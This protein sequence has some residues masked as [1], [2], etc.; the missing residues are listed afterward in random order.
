[1]YRPVQN[2]FGHNIYLNDYNDN[3]MINTLKSEIKNLKRQLEKEKESNIEYINKIETISS[4]RKELKEKLVNIKK[5][6]NTLNSEIKNLKRQLEK[7]KK[8]NT[9]YINKI[10]SISSE[11][12][13]LEKNLENIKNENN[14][15]RIDLLTK[16]EKINS[17][18]KDLDDKIQINKDLNNT[19]NI[20]TSKYKGAINQFEDMR[21]TLKNKENQ[22]KELKNDLNDLNGIKSKYEDLV[23]INN[24]SMPLEENLTKPAE[25]FYDVV[26]DITSI[27]AL[28]SKGWKIYYNKLRREVYQKIISDETIKLGVVGL[29]NVG[30][31]FILSK[32]SRAPLQSGYSL[33]TKGISIKYSEKEKGEEAGICVLD[34][35]GFETPLLKGDLEDNKKLNEERS[36]FDKNLQ[37]G[38]EDDLSRDKAQIERFIEQL[39]ISLSDLIIIVVGKISR[40]EQKLINQIKTLVKK[41]EK[42]KIKSI[43]VIHNLANY[44][45]KAEVEKYKDQYLVRSAT[46]NLEE[47]KAYG[48]SGYEDRYYFVERKNDENNIEV[49]H[50]LMAKEGQEAG[51]YYNSLTLELIRRNYISC[52]ERNKINIPEEIIKLFSETSPEILGEYRELEKSKEDEN[53]IKLA[54][55]KDSS[56][57]EVNYK[58]NV[59]SV[60]TD[61]DGNYNFF[62]EKYEPPYSLYFYKEKKK[63]TKEE[64]EEDEEEVQYQNVLLLR[65]EIPGNIVRL[66]ARSTKKESEKLDGIIIKGT[67]EED[68]F[69]EKNDENLK[70][71]KD[72]RTYKD[73]SYFIELDK[74]YILSE[75]YAKGYTKIYNFNFDKRNKEYILQKDNEKNNEKKKEPKY[76]N[77]ASG[78]YVFKF[79]LTDGSYYPQK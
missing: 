61:Q 42:K 72:N 74:N 1:M 75:E 76:Q 57:K 56:K 62:K 68:Q 48:I 31:T 46:F 20:K 50:Y 37:Y 52:N 15:L 35:A 28:K 30:K 54:D 4:E 65:L 71:I 16:E 45:Y 13:E 40:T 17:L 78:V 21:E 36:E 73:F 9:E 49:F 11:K 14:V 41:K 8:S 58:L 33:E 39:I 53:I 6:N 43:I 66:T 27:K 29:N 34:S 7:E 25:A 22:I 67:K 77:I 32:I 79:L 63:K 47:K 18:I 60:L 12:K 26:V 55:I 23:K 59:Q 44:Y 19:L 38:I 10:N 69:E 70:I 51:I 24:N 5:E 64:D 2:P 3:N